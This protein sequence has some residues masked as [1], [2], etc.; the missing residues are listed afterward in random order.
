MVQPTPDVLLFHGLKKPE[1]DTRATFSKLMVKVQKEC[2]VTI[3]ETACFME[4]HANGLPHH[5]CLAR[6]ATQYKWKQVA[7]KLFQKYKVSVSFLCGAFT[8]LCGA[9]YAELSQWM[10]S[11]EAQVPG[12]NCQNSNI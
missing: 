3:V 4:P 7:E 2:E 9:F 11:E 12:Q 5:N 6:A 8:G 1:E 10:A